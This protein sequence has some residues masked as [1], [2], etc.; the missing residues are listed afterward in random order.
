[1]PSLRSYLFKFML[2]RLN[3]FSSP[4]IDLIK[5][6]EKYSKPNP[7]SRKHKKVAVEEVE[8]DGIKCEW[9]IPNNVPQDRVIMYLHGGAWFM[10]SPK[11]HR[12]MV[13]HL[14]FL[15][16]SPALSVDYSL[17]PENPYPAGLNDCMTVYDWLIEK[18]YKSDKII[19]AGDSAGGNLT[20]ATLLKLKDEGKPLPGGAVAI[21]PATDLTDEMGKK[22]NSSYRTRR[23][24]DVFFSKMSVTT[25]T[26]PITGAYYTDNDP[27]TPY[28]SPLHGN[29]EGLPKMLIHVG[30]EEVLLDDT[31]EFV[32]KAK[33][34]RVD[35]TEV[36]WP[37]MFHVFHLWVPLLPEAKRA[38]TGIGKFIQEI[39][40]NSL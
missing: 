28:I 13:S 36:V 32:K 6:R 33:V 11:E 15:S 23:K 7:F 8:I 18:G 3:I 26:N 22:E 5:T 1:M 2:R 39:Q 38:L 9:L 30:D 31:L 35:I 29:L 37:H 4:N 24:K 21:S 14:A 17:A 10:G 25:D 34:A 20:I 19:I 16:K 27:K 12:A 40:D